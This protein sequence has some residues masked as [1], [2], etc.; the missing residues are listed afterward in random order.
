M[1]TFVEN[2]TIVSTRLGMEDH[3]IFTA[4]LELKFD[5]TG[6]GFGGYALDAPPA[7]R[8][9][10]S[11]RQP[12]AFGLGYIMELMRVLEADRWEKVSGQ[13]CRVKRASYMGPIVAI[14]HINK[15]QW[16]SPADYARSMGVA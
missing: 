13:F 14:G 11:K 7:E 6:Q 5:G 15:D 8:N 4:W 12:T 16:F 2:G 10:V 1:E 9:A 3:G